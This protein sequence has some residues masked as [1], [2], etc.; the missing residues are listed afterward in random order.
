MLIADLACRLPGE[1]QLA[2]IHRLR[3]L[4]LLDVVGGPW[5][6]NLKSPN[7]AALSNLPQLACLNLQNPMRLSNQS[8]ASLNM[9]ALPDRLQL[10]LHYGFS[11]HAGAP[12][13]ADIFSKVDDGLRMIVPSCL[14]F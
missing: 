6:N 7:W 8:L 1:D 12:V 3:H 14:G 9:K 11:H 4:E 10:A 13:R 5:L 2:D